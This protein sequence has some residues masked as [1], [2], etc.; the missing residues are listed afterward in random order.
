MKVVAFNGS[1]RQNGN[2][3]ILLKEVLQVLETEGIQT[4]LIQVVGCLYRD[5]LLVV[6]LALQ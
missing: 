5:V 4:S 6:G 1:P 2:T 3:S